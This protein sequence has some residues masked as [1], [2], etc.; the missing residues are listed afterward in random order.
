MLQIKNLN[1]YLKKDLKQ[2]ID[3]FSFT[4]SVNSKIALIGKEG[5]GKS[6]LLKAIYDINM[7]DEYA[8]VS[9]EINIKSE[10]ISYLPQEFTRECLEKSAK[11][12]LYEKYPLENFDYNSYYYYLNYFRLD[13]KIIDD[14]EKFKFFSGGEK[15]KFMLLLCMMK[16]P[17]ILLLDEPS[18]DLDLNS[19]KLL[20]KFITDIKIPVLFISHDE[21]FLNMCAN[22]IIHLENLTKNKTRHTIKNISYEE[23]IKERNHIIC[24]QNQQA[25][26]DKKEFDKQMEIYRN[27]HNKI[28]RE[29]RITKSDV[30]GKNLKDK[31]RSIKSM[32]KRFDKKEQTLTKKVVLETDINPIFSENV[33]NH[34]KKIILNL[35]LSNLKIE[36]RILAKNIDLKIKGN[37][38]ICIVGENGVGKTTLI[39]KIIST[40]KK[41]TL[42][43]YYMPQNYDNI[44]DFNKNP[45]EFLSTTFTKEEK[46]KVSNYLGCLNYSRKEMLRPINTLSGGQKCELFFARM[47]LGEYDF[48]ILDEPTRNLSPLSANKIRKSLKNYNGGILAI[49][50][51]LTFIKE[52]FDTVYIMTKDGLKEVGKDEI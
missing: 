27:I 42:K 48:L 1:I 8:K 44:L 38:K 19:L 32:G 25:I 34:N 17:T 20:E 26:N 52:V 10:I 47:I 13:E 33:G 9:G 35:K 31:M 4:I 11:N 7:V 18:N 29:L 50:H 14:N 16:S 30:V 51:D 49:S 5:N 23:Y 6:T 15:I 37:E 12:I 22:G 46:T 39:K 45:I 40:L 24:K 3:D 43:Y 36:N 2:L 28:Q 41:G 21:H